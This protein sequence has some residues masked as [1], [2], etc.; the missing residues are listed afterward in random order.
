MNTATRTENKPRK[1]RTAPPAIDFGSAKA[2]VST[3]PVRHTK[4]SGKAYEGTPV[5]ALLEQSWKARKETAPQS[6]KFRGGAVN[7]GPLASE[8]HAEYF[9]RLL[10]QCVQG[11]MPGVGVTSQTL[12]YTDG[13]NKGKHFVRFQTMT[14]KATGPKGPRNK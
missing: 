13:P 5:P 7:Y 1:V 12:T 8:E 4:A 9:R 3:E 10:T 14:R 6:N 2:E 11:E